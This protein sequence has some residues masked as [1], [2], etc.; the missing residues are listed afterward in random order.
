[1]T[2]LAGPAPLSA[3]EHAFWLLQ[4]LVPD[5]RIANLGLAIPHAKRLR[6]WPLQR[7]VDRMGARHPALRTRFPSV[8]GLPVRQVAAADEFALRVEFLPTT[9]ATCGDDLKEY[10]RRPFDLARDFPFRIACFVG[11]EPH[12]NYLCVVLHH[13]V[14]DQASYDVLTEELVQLYEGVA[15][16][17]AIPA[18]LGGEMPMLGELAEPDADAVGYW[19]DQLRGFDPSGLALGGAR[20]SPQRPTFAGRRMM[21]RLS[22]E[23]RAAVASLR[24]SERATENM[25]LLSAFCATLFRHGASPDLVVGVPVDARRGTEHEQIGFRVATLPLRLRVDPGRGFGEFVR[26]TRALFLAGV[27]HS[28]ASVED[29][30]TGLENRSTDWRIPLF[31]HMFNYRVESPTDLVLNGEVLDSESIEM[32]QTRL[33]IEF[34]IRPKPDGEVAVNI[35]YST[36]VHDEAWVRAFLARF[37]LLV[38]RAAAEPD[39]PLAGLDIRTSA[40]RALLAE[41]N[42]T[43]RTW[44]GGPT[45][46]DEIAAQE[47]ADPDAVAVVDCDRSFTRHEIGTAARSVAGAL[48]GRG[49]GPGDVVA[50]ALPRSAAL[51]ATIL[52]ILGCGAAYLPLDTGNPAR[53]L[54][55]QVADAGARVVVTAEPDHDWAA[56]TPVLPPVGFDDVA[57]PEAELAAGSPDATVYVI[58]TSGTTGRPK[59]VAVTHANLHNVV[60][61]FAERLSVDARTAVLWATTPAFDISALELFLPLCRGGRLVVAPAAHQTD[62]RALL[63]LIV[64]HDVDIVQATPTALQLLVDEVE[65]QLRGRVVLSGGEPLPAGLATRLLECGSRLYNVYGPTETTIWSA[66]ALLEEPLAGPVPIGRPLANTTVFLVDEHGAEMPPGMPGELCIG[67]AGVTLGYPGHSELTE[68]RFPADEAHGRHYRTGDLARVGEDGLLRLLGRNDRQ[69]KLRGHRIELAEIEAVLRDHD[70]VGGV[71]VT[72]QDGVRLSAFVRPSGA[73]GPDFAE[74][75]WRYAAEILPSYCLPSRIVLVDSF[76]VTANGKVDYS[77]LGEAGELAGTADDGMLPADVPADLVHRLVGVWRSVL[78][79]PGLGPRDNFF[80]NGG[81]SVLAVRLAQR[82][83]DDG[84]PDVPIRVVFDHPTPAGLARYL[85][86]AEVV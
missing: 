32:D 83:R 17:N 7:A 69:V 68:S 33:D 19:H 1:M 73:A 12:E 86:A 21:G 5:G 84:G 29:V 66:A 58:H 43:G 8:G 72:T 24:Q 44:D 52:G 25:V 81:H 80:L 38:Q 85:A 51:V 35:E 23:T 27:E 49:V 9:A 71:A 15:T 65:D 74:T 26:Q 67:G 64:R 46:L 2:T 28:S 3:R 75:L 11:P 40:E 45:V 41:L 39:R 14:G 36:E 60:R 18:G 77:R 57:G 56:D 30:L 13:I 10:A 76:P 79:R 53:R 37:E 78:D 62:P 61:D 42:H 20:P 16:T 4:Q 63:G 50:V 6:W 55:F 34:T 47:H 59:G 54:A 22:A 82:L 70:A 48:S 31:R